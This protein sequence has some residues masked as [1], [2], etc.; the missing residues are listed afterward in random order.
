MSPAARPSAGADWRDVPLAPVV[1]I[2]GPEDFIA[3]RARD[4]LRSKL[5]A[6]DPDLELTTLDA[7]AYTAGTLAMVA[8]PSLFSEPKLIEASGLASMSDDFLADALAYLKDPAPD[9]TLM[10]VHGGGTRGKKL[11]DALKA[12]GMPRVEC[13]ALKKDQEKAAFVTSEFQLAKRRIDAQAVRALVAAVGANLAELAAACQQLVSDTTGMVDSDAVDKYYGGRVEATAFRVADAALAGNAPAALA[14][15]RHALATG[16]DPVPLVAALAMKV[17]QVA[18]V[19]SLRGSSAQLARDLGMAPWQVDTARRDAGHWNAG[20][21]A[22]AVQALAE[23][24]AQVKG[25]A[26]D[27]VYA[28]ERAVTLIATS[29]RR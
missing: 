18:K 17:R 5:R 21:L 13:L 2:Y 1:L 16:V 8:S 20:G 14:N 11:L 27:P 6:Q 10:L 19:Y 3:S 7:A 26:R 22:A 15:L 9:V 23:A 24:D 4:G 25:A 12:A 28:V 29:A